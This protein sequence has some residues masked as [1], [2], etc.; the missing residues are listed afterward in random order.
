MAVDLTP[1]NGIHTIY[2]DLDGT[3]RH[4]RPSFTEV[5]SGF[6][7]QL[8]LPSEVANSQHA[9]RWLHYYWAQSPELVNDRDAFEE[10]ELS[11]WINHSSRYLLASGCP[12]EQAQ[13]LAP[14]LTQYMRDEYTPED[15]IAEDVP[16]LLQTLKESGYR[17]AV[18][19]NRRNPFDEQ[20]QSLGI[21]S[22]FEYS[23]AAGTI[24]TWKPDPKI[25]RH[26]LNEM[27]VEPENAL[28][29][30][31]NYFADVVG[32]QNAGINAVLIDPV[33]LFPEAD[34]VVIERLP[35]LESIL[36]E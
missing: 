6:I 26:A 10:D 28:Y 12:S 11:F 9:H 7:L 8:G 27:G 36:A 31:D 14:N 3:L 16:N 29:V 5:L 15:L 22:Y 32:A 25:F 23:L 34:C 35:E 18:V 17:L 33:N 30:G 21:D 24:N 1:W 2:F 19:S 20:L 4:N 13:K